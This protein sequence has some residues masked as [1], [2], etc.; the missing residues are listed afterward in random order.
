MAQTYGELAPK[1]EETDELI[2][3]SHSGQSV[4]EDTDFSSATLRNVYLSHME[5]SARLLAKLAE[6]KNISN[7]QFGESV[8]PGETKVEVG[9]YTH[10]GKLK[11]LERLELVRYEDGGMAGRSD[12]KFLSKLTKLKKLTVFD[13]LTSG[14]LQ[15]LLGNR[16][17][18]FVY[19]DGLENPSP[20]QLESLGAMQG[21]EELNLGFYSPLKGLSPLID[22]LY[23]RRQIKSLTLAA[24]NAL[25]VRDIEKICSMTTLKSLELAGVRSRDLPLFLKLGKIEVLR[26]RLVSGDSHLDL[27]FAE[28]FPN[29][30]VLE[31]ISD[32]GKK[33]LINKNKIN[34]SGKLNETAPR[35]DKNKV[36]GQE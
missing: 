6:C 22:K 30:R 9:A 21:I 29:L 31:I 36:P 23:A 33:T 11:N 26:I 27:D 24:K 19:V 12:D 20:E 35:K 4:S 13:D 25:E 2:T 5:I 16:N 32:K 8:G 1:F 28:S 14:D 7:L 34:G 3:L 17:L 10:I 15:G 18:E